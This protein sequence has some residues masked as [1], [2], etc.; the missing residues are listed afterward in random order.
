MRRHVLAGQVVVRFAEF[1]D[2]SKRRSRESC[3]R[4]ADGS[5][6]S[7]HVPNSHGLSG[8]PHVSEPAILRATPGT[9]RPPARPFQPYRDE[10][11]I[12]RRDTLNS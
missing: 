6:A 11:Y 7:V 2:C 10:S 4:V 5:S 8:G 3:V 12:S 1:H 9:L